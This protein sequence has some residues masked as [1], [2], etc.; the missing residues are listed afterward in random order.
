[1]LKAVGQDLDQLIDL[2]WFD[3][4]ARPALWLLKFLY[5]YTG[6]Y[7]IAI[8]LVTVL[9]KI[10]F[11]PLTHKSMKSMQA[12]QAVQPKI[13]AIQERYKNNP[14]KKQ[15]ET[16]AL[17]RKHGVNRWGAACRC[18]HRSQS[19]S[20]FITHFPPLLKCGR[21]TFCGFGT[22]A[23]RLALHGD[24]LGRSRDLRE[25][26]GAA[27]GCEHV[28]PA[29]DVSDDRGPTAGPD[30][31][32]DDADHLHL[33]VLEFPL[34]TGAVLAGEQHPSG[35][36]AVADQ[37]GTGAPA[38]ERGPTGL[39][40]P[41]LPPHTKTR[42]GLTISLLRVRTH[43]EFPSTQTPSPRSECIAKTSSGGR[44]G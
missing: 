13:Q 34:G 4:L 44:S 14:Q 20:L 1:V 23:T 18:W 5:N 21:R 24:A 35:R 22:D 39:T 9:Q 41:C 7:G 27:H 43:W 10:A 28:G 40:A 6:N 16:M 29:K 2:G 17:Y 15:E 37:P 26:L 12:M 31:A 33:H 42:A 3:F 19:S 25:S 30:D 8:I 36:P 32:L 11:H 38:S